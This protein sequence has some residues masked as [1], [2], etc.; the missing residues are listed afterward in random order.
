MSILRLCRYFVSVV[1]TGPARNWYV[2]TQVLFQL[3][4]VASQTAHSKLA[5]W[6]L[7]AMDSVR[8]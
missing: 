1:L 4:K 3:S 5:I 6:R 8:L 7:D 2:G